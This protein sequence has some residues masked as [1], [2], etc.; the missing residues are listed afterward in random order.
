M[1][2]GAKVVVAG[3][4]RPNVEEMRGGAGVQYGAG[5]HHD[6]V[7]LDVSNGRTIVIISPIDLP[8]P[9]EALLA[10]PMMPTSFKD[11]ILENPIN[12]V[13]CLRHYAKTLP[14]G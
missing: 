13:G 8:V 14:L 1:H 7:T 6:L 10:F 12:E 9:P 5:R 3:T 11:H 2:H 4:G